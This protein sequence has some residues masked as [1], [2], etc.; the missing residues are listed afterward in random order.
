[1]MRTKRGAGPREPAIPRTDL[2]EEL[3]LDVSELGPRALALIDW[4]RETPNAT[5]A[6]TRRGRPLARLVAVAPPDDSDDRVD[7]HIE[8]VAP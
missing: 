4:L 2:P 8:A 1:M 3:T 5:V 6:V 7:W